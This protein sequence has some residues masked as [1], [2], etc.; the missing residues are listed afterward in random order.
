MSTVKQFQLQ[1]VYFYLLLYKSIC[2][3]YSS[4]LYQQVKAIQMS[5]NN[6]FSYEE[7]QKKYRLNIIK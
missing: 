3:W 7:N 6:I 4:E 1:L 5:T 2:N